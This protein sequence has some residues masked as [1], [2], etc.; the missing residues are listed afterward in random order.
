MQRTTTNQRIKLA[1]RAK[2]LEMA[3]ADKDRSAASMLSIII[4]RAYAEW[5]EQPND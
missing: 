5:K 4:G 2:L 1:D 3:K